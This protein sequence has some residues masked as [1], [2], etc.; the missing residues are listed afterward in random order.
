MGFSFGKNFKLTIFGESHGKIVGSIVEGCPIGLQLKEEDI[1]EELNKRKPGGELTSKREEKD[2]VNILSG[3]TNGRTNG[4]PILMLIFNKDVDSTWYEKHRYIPRPGHADYPA[5]IKYGGYNDSR[6]GGFF[7]GRLT[8]GFVMAGAIAKKIL[9]KKGIN[10][11]THVIQINGIK[12]KENISDE[13]IIKLASK[14]PVY[15]ADEDAS[16]QMV[17]EIKRLMEEGDST[18]GIIECRVLGLPV[19]IGEPIFDSVESILAHGLFSIPGVKAIEFGSGFQ[20]CSMRG[21]QSNDEFY[22]KEGK[23]LTKTNH[24]GGILG[25][26]T[27]GMPLVFR[28]GIKPTS[29]ISKRQRSVNLITM[30]ETELE[31]IGRH[32]PC[33]V[34]RAVPVVEC[35]TAFC[36][37]DLMMQANMIP[38][39]MSE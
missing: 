4:G 17:A 10:I 5:F 38:R 6:G 33:I 2:I 21:S 20:L 18:G 13:E 39:I 1:Q 37:T 24:S 23:I 11:L 29:S 25:G 31:I 9:T 27:N 16:K 28:V 12:A 8:V 34:I 26:L 36:I 32:D 3:V 19:G 14:S 7:S 22:I 30:K 35:V 15:C